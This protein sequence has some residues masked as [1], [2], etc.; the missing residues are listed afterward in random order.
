MLT[1]TGVAI[2]LAEIRLL[3]VGKL[4]EL[5][6]IT[7]LMAAAAVTFVAVCATGW[8]LL[9]SLRALATTTARLFLIIQRRR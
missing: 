6:V 1:V 5:A 8:A 7:F 9:L 3:L 2:L 4:D